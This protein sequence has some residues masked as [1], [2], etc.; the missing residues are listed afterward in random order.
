MPRTAAG[1]VSEYVMPVGG[2][3]EA[4]GGCWCCAPSGSTCTPG[5]RT[6]IGRALL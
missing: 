4:L 2:R 5:N 3:T 1:P 6:G